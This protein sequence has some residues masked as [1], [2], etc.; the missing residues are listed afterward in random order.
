MRC[1]SHNCGRKGVPGGQRRLWIQRSDEIRLV[2]F[3]ISAAGN[4]L[5]MFAEGVARDNDVEC[6]RDAVFRAGIKAI[7]DQFVKCNDVGAYQ[8][9][10]KLKNSPRSNSKQEVA[11][12]FCTKLCCDPLFAKRLTAMESRYEQLF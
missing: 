11:T 1:C 5:E 8:L 12:P 6:N 7:L 4:L 10:P 9:R 3:Q 2:R